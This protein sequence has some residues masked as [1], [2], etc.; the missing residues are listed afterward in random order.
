M[1]LRVLAILVALALPA[2]PAAAEDAGLIGRLVGR[3]FVVPDAKGA[4]VPLQFVSPTQ[5]VVEVRI[6]GQITD[7]YRIRADGSGDHVLAAAPDLVSS[8]TF[9]AESWSRTYK[10]LTVTYVLSDD[11]DL[12][13]RLS[14]AVEDWQAPSSVY[15]HNPS[16]A[17]LARRLQAAVERAHE[18][19]DRFEG[20][21]HDHGE[22]AQ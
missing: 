13:A 11:G 6:G 12:V 8:A 15:A 2:A 10:G 18:E 4:R 19:A 20:H 16:H 1:F 5:G 22:A 3:A 21:D 17:D 14:G 9:A 7:S